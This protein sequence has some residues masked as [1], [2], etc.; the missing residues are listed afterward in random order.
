MV[1]ARLIGT[2]TLVLTIVSCQSPRQ[3]NEMDAA[4]DRS[5]PRVELGFDIDG[6]GRPENLR[7]LRASMGHESDEVVTT[8]FSQW[9]FCPRGFDKKEQSIRFD[10]EVGCSAGRCVDGR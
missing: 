4:P 8:A 10:F 7:V 6:Q 3:S 5:R 9:I 2:A 1:L